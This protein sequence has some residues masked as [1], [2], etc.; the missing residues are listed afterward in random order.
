MNEKDFHE[1]S[2]IPNFASQPRALSTYGSSVFNILRTS[3][4]DFGLLSI[5]LN[6][7]FSSS[8]VG[9]INSANSTIFRFLY[10]FNIDNAALKFGG[11]NRSRI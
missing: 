9:A 6:T 4:A 5:A 10:F 8:S 2:T 1:K 7:Q 3:D 11:T